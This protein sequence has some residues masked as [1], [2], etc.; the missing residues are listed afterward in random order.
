MRV[1]IEQNCAL[2]HWETSHHAVM[3]TKE[4]TPKQQLSVRCPVIAI[5]RQL[6][7]LFRMKAPVNG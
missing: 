3:K 7:I 6:I 5:F 4:L 2:L 1:E